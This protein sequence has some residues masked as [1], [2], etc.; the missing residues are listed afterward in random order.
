MKGERRA[1][2]ENEE[3]LE[4][5]LKEAEAIEETSTFKAEEIRVYVESN[6][7]QTTNAEM[8]NELTSKTEIM[9]GSDDE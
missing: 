6:L 9:E 8:D 2:R 1:E 4:V 7:D 5:P 3:Q